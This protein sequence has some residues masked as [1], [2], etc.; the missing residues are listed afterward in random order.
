MKALLVF[1]GVGALMFAGCLWGTVMGALVGWVVG[2]LFDGT[3]HLLAQALGIDAQPY[4]LGAMFG[5]LGGFFR[6][7]M[8]VKT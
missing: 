5:F 1:W 4:Q 7:S 2:L 3:M 6:A 8:E